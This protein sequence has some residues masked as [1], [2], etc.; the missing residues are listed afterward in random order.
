MNNKL[1]V[2]IENQ[3][4][5]HLKGESEM[6]IAFLEAYYEWLESNETGIAPLNY[7]ENRID[8]DRTLDEFSKRIMNELSENFPETLELS[9]EKIVK[10]LRT[11]YSSKG[12]EQSFKLLFRMLFKD[13]VIFK[14]PG[15]DVFA[16]SDGRWTIDESVRVERIEQEGNLLYEGVPFDLVQKQVVFVDELFVERG[17]A[18]VDRVSFYYQGALPVYE[19]FFAKG[20]LQGELQANWLLYERG[21]DI[22]DQAKTRTRIYSTT[23]EATI[24]SSTGIFREG[25]ILSVT[26]GGGAGSKIRITTVDSATGA[27]TNIEINKFGINYNT[28]FQQT[29]VVPASLGLDEA[30][31]TV[32]FDVGALAIYPGYFRTNNGKI[33]DIVRIQDAN[34]YQ[35][36][37]YVIQTGVSINR[38]RN[39]VKEVLHPAGF[40]FFGELTFKSDVSFA[41]TLTVQQLKEFINYPR[42]EVQI[43][44]DETFY[45]IKSRADTQLIAEN[46]DYRFTKPR[47]DTQGLSDDKDYYFTKPRSDTQGLSDDRNNNFTKTRTET[48]GLSDDK[49]YEFNKSRSDTQELS[50]LENRSF[51]KIRSDSQGLSDLENR[52]FTKIRDDAQAIQEFLVNRLT[53]IL[54]DTLTV[55]DEKDFNL[56]KIRDRPFRSADYF[57]ENY[58]VDNDSYVAEVLEAVYVLDEIQIEKN[59]T[60]VVG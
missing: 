45:I 40:S 34:R 12:T 1:K 58:L 59:G 55:A 22:L 46:K 60:L 48:Q 37:A 21:A 36:F 4:P 50:D 28:P 38:W 6:L 9:R 35:K 54:E 39:I 7:A 13:D 25:T 47:S 30:T 56:T 52:S 49:D 19:I 10:Q 17:S 29:F 57:A 43:V 20:T 11:L 32:N 53:K 33:S 18:V 31:V 3:I 23:T 24:A 14:Y 2:L 8:I 5:D 26:S 15:R 44:D 42:D 41:S 51:T 16:P 27:P